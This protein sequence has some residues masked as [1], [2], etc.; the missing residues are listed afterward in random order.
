MEILT[1]VCRS[2]VSEVKSSERPA[3]GH[4][5]TDS[6]GFPLCGSKCRDGSKA[7]RSY[8]MPFKEPLRFGF[9]K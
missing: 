4:L 6:L 5:A 9:I 8:I 7:P 1:F 3:T 2:A